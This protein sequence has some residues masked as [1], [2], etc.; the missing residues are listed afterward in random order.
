MGTGIDVF[1]MD[2]VPFDDLDEYLKNSLLYQEIQTDSF[3]NNARIRD[4][5]EEYFECKEHEAA[6]GKTAETMRLRDE[7]EKYGEEKPDDL[8]VVRLWFNRPRIYEPGMM[9]D[10][11][12]HKFE[13][14]EFPVPARAEECL[15]MQYGPDWNVVPEDGD[16][17]IHAFKI[18]FDISANNYYR[19]I[20]EHA[21]WEHLDEVLSRRKNVRIALLDKTRKLDEFRKRLAS[22]AKD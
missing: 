17:G 16:R 1:L 10:P 9:A 7:L 5:K 14:T 8:R 2:N 15:R 6:A 13:D 22:G 21:D 4:H 18:D 19:L 20:D 11:V 3:I 12:L